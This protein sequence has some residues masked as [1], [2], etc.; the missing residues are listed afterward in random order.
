MREQLPAQSTEPTGGTPG[1][2]AQ[3]LRADAATWSRVVKD[4]GIRAD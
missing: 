1:E 4:A 2:F 3:T